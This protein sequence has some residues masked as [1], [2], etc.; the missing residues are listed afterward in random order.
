MGR[1]HQLL[2]QINKYTAFGIPLICNTAMAVCPEAFGIVGGGN[3]T[4][5]AYFLQSN[6]A[7]Y[8]QLLPNLG[9]GAVNSVSM[10]G[11]G[12]GFIGGVA[13]GN[14]FAYYVYQKGTLSPQVLPLGISAI[15]SVVLN[16]VGTALIGGTAGGNA[17]AYL[18]FPNLTL[19][20]QLLPTSGGEII[21]VDINVQGQGLVG[22]K[23]GASNAIAHVIFPNGTVSAQLL[24][25]A[26]G[27]ETLSVAVNS[28]GSGIVGGTSGTSQAFSYLVSPSA[29]LSPQLLPAITGVTASV[30]INNSNVGLI[31]GDGGGTAPFAYFVSANGTLSSQLLPPLP[32]GT[33]TSV[34]INDSQRGLI[35]GTTGFDPMLFIA[36]PDGTLSS[37]LLPS[38]FGATVTKVALNM[39]NTGL[40][41]GNNGFNSIA[42]LISP[43][44]S[45]TTIYPS[46][47]G[48]FLE[49]AMIEALSQIITEC[50]GGNNLTVAKYINKYAPEKAFYFLPA[51]V[52]GTLAKALQSVAPTRNAASL[53]T[54]DNNVFLLNQS[55]SRH[56]RD[57][58]YV[59]L[60]DWSGGNHAGEETGWESDDQLFASL[61]I[62]SGAMAMA[63]AEQGEQASGK[64]RP[65]SLWGEVVG[66]FS[67]Q[68]AEHQTPGFDPITGGFLLGIE[69]FLDERSL[70]GGG[71]A[72]TYTHIHQ[73]HGSGHSSINQEYL[74]AY[75]YWGDKHFYFDGALWGGLFQIHQV[76]KIHMTG[77]N[78]RSVSNPDGWQLSPHVEVGGD[79][80]P[81]DSWLTIE[82]FTMF[83]WT[84]AWQESYKEKGSGPFNMGQKHHYSSFLRSELGIRFYE[85]I[86]FDSWRLTFQEKA[87]YV[88]KK[89]FNIGSVNA[90]LVG[91]PG[92]FTVETFTTP[93]NLGVAELAVIFEPFDLIYPFGT[94]A[95]QGEFSVPFQ[96]H[97]ILLE[98]CWSF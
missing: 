83:D 60:Y 43:S 66:A 67:Y 81:W 31:G 16:D 5:E 55:L 50:L 98:L 29:T 30:A 2:N 27:G 88:N 84:N 47:D 93:Q 3:G 1:I 12:T 45:I 53:I 78:F 19:S 72:Y 73:H 68:K 24:P 7:Y 18:V 40:A 94:I 22:G 79:F 49:A 35:G 97:Q 87:S 20:P 57:Q 38:Q 51:L 21:T 54:A 41:I 75:G 28:N 52:D 76:R 86:V 8:P 37:Q 9:P 32:I 96:S 26:I 77:F 69:K 39:F 63:D 33:V 89:P 70:V 17:S 90:F 36:Y 74:F 65:Y 10:N 62:P 58:R 48:I 56:L 34:A 85:A 13:S 42:F 14:A 6:G 95:Y 15:N 71:A 23:D 44:G 64:D 25:G 46:L 92:S 82:P 91:S 80:Y 61:D 4:P 11:S 59:R